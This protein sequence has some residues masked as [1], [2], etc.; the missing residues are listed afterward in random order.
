MCPK[1]DNNDNNNIQFV[2]HHMSSFGNV[3]S[4]M[5]G[6]PSSLET[7]PERNHRRLR[8]ISPAFNI[9]LVL[10]AISKWAGLVL[11]SEPNILVRILLRKST[12]Y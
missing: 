7:S 8:P 5:D 9:D 12:E 10:A 6:S 2:T 4:H 3:E 1:M 11:C